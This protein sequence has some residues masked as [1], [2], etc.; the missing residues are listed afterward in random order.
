MK[1]RCRKGVVR[2]G[3]NA[4]DGRIDMDTLFPSAIIAERKA[5]IEGFWRGEDIGRPLFVPVPWANR[6]WPDRVGSRSAIDERI[7]AYR[8][9]ARVPVDV[10]PAFYLG[11]GTVALAS[12][13]GGKTTTE[14]NG[15]SWINPIIGEAD[16]AY[17]LEPP[18]PTAGLIGEWIG[19]YREFSRSV[20]GFIPIGMPDMQGP[21]QTASQLWGTERIILE[22]YD[23]PEAV[24]RSLDVVTEYL[25][26]VVRHL[27]ENFVDTHVESYPPAWFPPDLGQGLVED[28]VQILS[29]R[30]YEEFGLPYVNRIADAFGGIWLHCCATCRQHWPAFRKI[31]GLRGLDTMYPYTNPQEVFAAFPS[32]VHSIGLDYAESRRNFGGSGPDGWLEFLLDHVPRS[33]R[34]AFVTGCDDPDTVP[35]QLE[36]VKKRW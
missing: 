22:M 12:A 18:E 8:Y 36:L 6:P 2:R 28:F 15:K 32:I 5:M 11:G 30:L 27:R 34:W 9:Q 14:S 19:T 23:H 31:H 33:V 4:V 17:T 24:H 26:S 16:E 25:I 10:I 20:D 3:G 29:P 21:L 1:N 7:D 13:F 35:R